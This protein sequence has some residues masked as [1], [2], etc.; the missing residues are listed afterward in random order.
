M[1]I[2]FWI[3]QIQKFG[4]NINLLL[5]EFQGKKY[6]LTGEDRKEN[7]RNGAA[8]CAGRR[9]MEGWKNIFRA[10]EPLR[11]HY[12]DCICFCIWCEMLELS[13]ICD[14]WPGIHKKLEFAS[15]FDP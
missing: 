5:D 13:F 12:L 11:R 9:R 3:C 7:Q 6:W 14:D 15:I 1:Y 4:L 2:V 10:S 8:K